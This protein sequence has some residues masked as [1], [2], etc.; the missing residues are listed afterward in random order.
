MTRG[1]NIDQGELFEVADRL[2]SE[3]KEVT[4]LAV[5]TALG[6]GSYTT[7]YKYLEAWRASRPAPVAPVSFQMPDPVKNIFAG[8]WRMALME[9]AK[10]TEAVKVKAAEDLKN[11][12]AQLHGA[13]QAIEK[14]ELAAEAS[15]TEIASLKESSEQKQAVLSKT[16]AE[17]SAR[18]NATEDLRRQLVDRDS[19]IARLREEL[20]KGRD[21]RDLAI[22]EAAELKG[23]MTAIVSQNAAL[24]KRVGKI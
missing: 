7:V 13:L 22:K 23:K 12:A 16:E 14:L 18:A 6:R 8:A 20:A 5:Q 17:L 21:E 15:A 11:A 9:S 1:P 10:E 2:E 4:A 24:L 3:G 19:E